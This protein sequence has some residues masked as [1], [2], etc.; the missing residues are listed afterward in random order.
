LVRA[1]NETVAGR[2]SGAAVAALV[3]AKLM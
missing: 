1:V 3:K 2:A